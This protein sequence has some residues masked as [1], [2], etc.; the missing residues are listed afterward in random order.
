MELRGDAALKELAE[1]WLGQGIP[2]IVVE[3]V[4]LRGSAPREVGARML[5]SALNCVGSVG[6][7]HLE[8]QA[9]Q[10]ARAAL[11]G[12]ALPESEC[13]LRETCRPWAIRCSGSCPSPARCGIRAR[14]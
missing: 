4:A 10:T 12:E 1:Q 11:H 6:G 13:V 9:L 14:S 8:W 7:G 2:G 5:V 3:V